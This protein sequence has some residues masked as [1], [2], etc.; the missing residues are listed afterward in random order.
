MPS[1]HAQDK[2]QVLV[3]LPTPLVEAVRSKLDAERRTMTDLIEQA[4][5]DYITAGPTD[6][7]WK[8]G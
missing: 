4:L 6:P 3:R 5:T 1:Q 2:S 7:D 8:R